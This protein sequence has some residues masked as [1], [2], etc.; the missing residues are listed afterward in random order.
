[1]KQTSPTPSGTSQADFKQVR[2]YLRNV[3][4]RQA[5]SGFIKAGWTPGELAE[6]ARQIY[7]A[8]GRTYPTAMS[9]QHAMDK[10][11]EHPFA[12]ETLAS[13]RA[14]GVAVPQFNRPVPKEYAWDDP[15]SPE[16]TPELKAEIAELCRL[17]RNREASRRSEQWPTEDL[18]I[19]RR[20]WRK[21]FKIRNRYHSLGDTIEIQ[22]LS[23]YREQ[24]LITP[25]HL[26]KVAR[27][28][29][30]ASLGLL[31]VP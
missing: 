19:P 13:L 10:G 23:R 12:L 15:D 24:S 20:L 11:A 29:P 16:H 31:R 1:V 18:P 7:L 4:Q 26:S 6:F 2:K 8:P 25:P 28:T 9:Y 27:V 5:L 30:G 21:L 3:Q 17:W 14:P 22:R